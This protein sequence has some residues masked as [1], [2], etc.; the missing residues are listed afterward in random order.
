MRS[1]SIL[2]YMAHEEIRIPLLLTC[3]RITSLIPVN[4]LAPNSLK[5][6]KYLWVQDGSSY[7]PKDCL[8]HLLF[9]TSML[10]CQYP[11]IQ[12]ERW[13]DRHLSLLAE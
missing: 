4:F 11:T 5:C 7:V 13:I 10:F 8:P 1:R 6:G 2:Y 12:K 9:G 3:R